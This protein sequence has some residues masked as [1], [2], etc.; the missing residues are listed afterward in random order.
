[1]VARATLEAALR[2]LRP[3]R[4]PRAQPALR[5]PSAGPLLC[6]LCAAS[7]PPTCAAVPCLPPFSLLPT[8]GSLPPPFSGPRVARPAAPCLAARADTLVL[9][10]FACASPWELL[11]LGA[12]TS[13]LGEQLQ[14]RLMLGRLGLLGLYL[15]CGLASSVASARLRRSATGA[16]GLLGALAYHALAAPRA[17]HSFFGLPLS[18]RLG[19]AAQ[20]LFASW[21]G[22]NQPGH[23]VPVLVINGLPAVLG[24]AWFFASG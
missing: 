16:G 3:L 4:A 15:G 10:A 20:F 21:G 18:A 13:S 23:A 24:A 6:A 9:G 17:T 12:I 5:L 2:P 11:W 8:L 19:F 1:M 22:L 7:Q 14:H